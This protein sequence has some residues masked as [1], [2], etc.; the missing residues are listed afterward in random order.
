MVKFIEDEIRVM[1]RTASGVRG[2][3]LDGGECIGA[4]IATDTDSLIIVT[5]QG[6]GK[7]TIISD[8][9]QTRRGSKGVK[10][11]NI[12][13]KNGPMAAFRLAQENSDLII[14]TNTGMVIRVPLDQ[15][16]TLGRVTQGVRVINLKGEQEVSNIS[17]VEK[18][19]EITETEVQDENISIEQTQVESD[20]VTSNE[21]IESDIPEVELST[22][23]KENEN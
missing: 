13:E 6:Y 17:L 20:T 18:T 15:I 3:N 9:R 14:I 19:P 10:A 7:Q 11:L 21:K 1:G 4:E 22:E 2:I 23:V 12:T 16:N 5:K 8:Y